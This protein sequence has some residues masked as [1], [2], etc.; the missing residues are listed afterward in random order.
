MVITSAMAIAAG[1]EASTDEHICRYR[2]CLEVACLRSWELQ[3]RCLR[4]PQAF[5]EMPEDAA[6]VQEVTRLDLG[7]YTSVPGQGRMQAPSLDPLPTTK[8]SMVHPIHI[9]AFEPRVPTVSPSRR[10]LLQKCFYSEYD[11]FWNLPAQ[12]LSAT[13]ISSDAAEHA[14]DTG[15]S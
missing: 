11:V 15:T 9:Y 13:S 3:E 7:P 8:I 2:D 14:A 12:S 6:V 1:L 5:L 10:R 4:I